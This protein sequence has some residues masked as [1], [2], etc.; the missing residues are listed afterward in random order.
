MPVSAPRT[1]R[2]DLDE[3]EGSAPAWSGANRERPVRPRRRGRRPRGGWLVLPPLLLQSLLAAAALALIL[4]AASLPPPYGPAVRHA[5]S[6][7]LAADLDLERAVAWARER[8]LGERTARLVSG[9]LRPEP[10]EAAISWVWPV[11]GTVTGR[12]GWR[13]GGDGQPEFHE[14]IDIA[15]PEGTPV[16]A[17]APGAVRR[18]GQHPELGLFVEIEHGG[19]WVS[20]YAHLSAASVQPGDRVLQGQ[21]VGRVGSEGDASGPHLHFELRVRQGDAERAVDP[22]PKLQRAQGP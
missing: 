9:I 10:E 13:T 12:F 11:E 15:A 19:G 21:V 4:G 6:R 18:V 2:D 7:A 14:G 16:V 22:E 20:R 5:V 1:W 8:R 17:A 3:G